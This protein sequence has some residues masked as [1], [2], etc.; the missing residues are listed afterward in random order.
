MHANLLDRVILQVAPERGRNRIKARAQAQA[1]MNFD[2]ASTGCRLKAWKSPASDAD[3][4]SF[5]GRSRMRQLSRDMMRNAPFANRAKQVVKGNVVGKGI[6]PSAVCPKSRKAEADRKI[7]GHLKS[8]ALDFYGERDITAQQRVVMDSVFES[9]EVLALRRP[10]PRAAAL[11]L[12]FQVQLLEIDHLDPT[13]QTHG[14]NEVRDGVEYDAQ[15]RIVAYHIYEMHPGATTR[16]GF[17]LTSKRWPA[18]EVIHIRRLDRVGQTRG[19]PWLAPVMVTLGELRDYQEAQLLKQKMS[20]LL[21][22]VATL[23]DGQ[24]VP[25]GSGLDSLSPG[26]IAYAAA[27]SK[28]EWSNPPKVD[29]YDVVMRHGL[30]AIAMG[31]GIT[32]EALAGDLA[33]VNFSSSRVGRLEMEHNV[34]AWQEEIIIGQFCRGVERWALEAYQLTHNRVGACNISLKWTPPARPIVDPAKELDPVIKE[35]GEGITSLQ[36][37]QRE[38]GLDPDEIAAERAEDAERLKAFA[39]KEDPPAKPGGKDDDGTQEDPEG[40]QVKEETPEDA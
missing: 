26:A 9:G 23:E 30:L 16:K 21:A 35:I 7:I 2:A 4:A 31:V 32:Y 27:G 14:G 20:A 3:A 6:T 36:R 1:I 38:R 24:T 29:D 15:D 10:A 5:A 28:F 37:A 11:E 18:S 33:R 39:P 25:E 40:A 13:I 12:P 19:W 17:K 8:K 34:K 22:G